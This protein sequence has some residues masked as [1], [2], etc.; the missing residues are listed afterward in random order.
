MLLELLVL[1]C[2]QSSDHSIKL[3]SKPLNLSILSIELTTPFIL[4]IKRV[5]IMFIM[6][7]QSSA[8][9]REFTLRVD[10]WQLTMEHV[11]SMLIGED[12]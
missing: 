11:L 2:V 5:L 6:P 7:T 9:Q 4:V 8:L 3:T 10:N 12:A 1:Q